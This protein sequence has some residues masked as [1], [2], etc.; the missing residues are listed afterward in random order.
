MQI[1]L[2]ERAFDFND[3]FDSFDCFEGHIIA[4]KSE[5]DVRKIAAAQP[6]DEGAELWLNPEKSIV[7]VVNPADYDKP[8]IILSDFH[9]A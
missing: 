1:F 6:G 4:A 3:D 5:E 2:I 7:T 9:A 8:A